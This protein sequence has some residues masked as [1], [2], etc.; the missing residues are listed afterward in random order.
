MTNSLDGCYLKRYG[1]F[2]I[3]SSQKDSDLYQQNMIKKKLR[4]TSVKSHYH[5]KYKRRALTLMLPYLKVYFP[6]LS[7]S[8]EN[9]KGLVKRISFR[10]RKGFRKYLHKVVFF[11][12][13]KRIVFSRFFFSLKRRKSQSNTISLSMKSRKKRKKTLLRIS[14]KKKHLVIIKSKCTNEQRFGKLNSIIKYKKNGHGK[15]YSKVDFQ[16]RLFRKYCYGKSYVS[17]SNLKVLS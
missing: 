5:K 16:A 4:V 2:F 8:V 12:R 9:M 11:S 6:H 14:I 10:R 17:G 15:N 13:I 7:S 1:V 3:R